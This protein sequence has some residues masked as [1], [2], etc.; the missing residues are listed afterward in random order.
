MLQIVGYEYFKA[1]SRVGD[2][3][4]HYK[5]SVVPTAKGTRLATVGELQGLWQ[6][7]SQ[8][9]DTTLECQDEPH[10]AVMYQRFQN[11]L[12]RS[13]LDTRDVS[14]LHGVISGLIRNHAALEPFRIENEQRDKDGTRGKSVKPPQ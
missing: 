2:G 11:I 1:R 12:M 4:Y 7:A 8:V 14:S 10:R 13:S 9:L 3:K 6:R 5:D